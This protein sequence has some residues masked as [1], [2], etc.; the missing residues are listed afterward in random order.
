MAEIQIPEGYLPA[1]EYIGSLP[2]IKAEALG[3]LINDLPFRLD[4]EG[5]SNSV[6]ELFPDST[7]VDLGPAIFSLG[8]ILINENLLTPDL[9]ESLI[10]DYKKQKGGQ[11]ISENLLAVFNGIGQLVHIFKAYQLQRESERVLSSVRILTDTRFCF[12]EDLE[13]SKPDHGIVL[14]HLKLEFT[15]KGI[16]PRSLFFGL[17]RDDLKEL[18]SAAER[19]LAKEDRIKTQFPKDFSWFN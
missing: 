11:D 13:K 1:F 2:L 19:A 9:A 14:H 5:F 16:K 12:D 8:P 18:I 17:D 15:S 10:S 4:S 7:S 3:K 6:Y